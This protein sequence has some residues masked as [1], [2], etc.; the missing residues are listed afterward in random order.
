ML[1]DLDETSIFGDEDWSEDL[2]DADVDLTPEL[3]EAMLELVPC[4]EK[5]GRQRWR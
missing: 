4:T 5:S 2:D 1:C 3:V